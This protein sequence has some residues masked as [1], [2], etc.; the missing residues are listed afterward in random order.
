MTVAGGLGYTYLLTEYQNASSLLLSSIEELQDSTSR[1][2]GYVK[3]IED[4]E[5]SLK[6]VQQSGASSKDITSLRQEMHKVYNGINV[7]QL[8]LKAKVV[9]LG[10][11]PCIDDQLANKCRKRSGQTGQKSENDCV[12]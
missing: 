2:A 7:E 9:D 10:I 3:R 6:K 11:H 12:R 5:N 4:V 8:D 1:I